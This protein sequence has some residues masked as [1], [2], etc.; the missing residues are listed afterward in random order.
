[1]RR[2]VVPTPARKLVAL[3]ILVPDPLK[4]DSGV[5]NIRKTFGLLLE[6]ISA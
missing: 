4:V 6:E 5:R 3:K 2:L 1:M